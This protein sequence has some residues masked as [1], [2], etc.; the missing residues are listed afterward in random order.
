[1]SQT[2]LHFQPGQARWVHERN[3]VVFHAMANGRP[4]D[5]LITCEALARLDRGRAGHIGREDAL[6]VFLAHEAEIHR[7]AGQEYSRRGGGAPML[8]G[9]RDI[10]DRPQ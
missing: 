4:V 10:P 8:F 9:W 2:N 7:I 5:F 3:G 6:R 1:M